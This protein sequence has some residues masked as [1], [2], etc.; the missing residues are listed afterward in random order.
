MN[1]YLYSENKQIKASYQMKYVKKL[2]YL[3]LVVC[4]VACNQT[5]E[6]TQK[7]V[8]PPF[9][10]SNMV[11]QQKSSVPLFGEATPNVELQI[12]SSWDEKAYMVKTNA[13]GDFS[14]DL[15]TPAYG[16]PYQ[17]TIEQ[18]KEI[19]T[20]DN[21]L[22][23][24]V[25]LCSGQSNME[26]PLAGWGKI[27]NYEEE[28]ANANYPKIRLLQATHQYADTPQDT[29]QIDGN[30]WKVCSPENIPEFSSTAYFFARKVY[31]TTQIPVGLI[32]SSWGGTVAEA[33]TSADALRNLHDFDKEIEALTASEEE[34]L[35]IEKANQLKLDQWN[36]EVLKADKGMDMGHAIWSHDPPKT[37]W[38]PMELPNY[39]DVT[40]LPDLDGSV[41]FQKEI[42]LT[43]EQVAN[44]ATLHFFADDEDMTWV[45][46]TKVGE[47]VGYN[48]ARAYEIPANTFQKGNNR[49]TIRVF[50]GASG[51]GIYGSENQLYLTTGTDTISLAGNWQYQV[52]VDLK[53]VAPRPYIPGP[54]NQPTILYNAMIHPLLKIPFRGVIWY[55]GESNASRAAQYNKLFPTLI[56]DWRA[57]FSNGEMPFYFVQLAAYMQRKETP[58]ASEWAELREAQLNALKLPNTGM[59]VAIDIGNADDIHPKNKQEVGARLARIALNKVYGE[60]IPFSGP[61]YRSF[62]KKDNSIVISFDHA[63]GLQTKDNTP[64]KGFAIAGEDQKFY[65]ATAVIEGNQV[66]V[67]SPKVPNPVAVRYGWD[68]NPDVNL[69][70]EAALPASP[71]RTDDWPGITGSK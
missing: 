8:L 27:Q 26:M 55:Q 61:L 67:S 22:I 36:A 56:E 7:I 35:A 62:E 66:R 54:P 20:L 23:G 60:R 65:W 40:P 2:A 38:K 33:W 11:L 48:V 31:E 32:H 44:T 3:A 4:I 57:Q 21:V 24:E 5:P 15:Q 47:T 68:A 37:G 19:Y 42:K 69:Y 1:T 16:G 30:G 41:W 10:S 6:I 28:I 39:W 50:D 52:G 46:G 29:I 59:A 58:Q 9:F 12:T 43:A 25:W 53:E 18:N 17:I 71:F 49:I 13:E 63:N 64:L 45:N 14:V 70:N 51:G 34:K